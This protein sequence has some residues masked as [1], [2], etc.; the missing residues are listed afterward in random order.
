MAVA[1]GLLLSG[2]AS[3]RGGQD[4]ACADFDK[5]AASP[6]RSGFVSD[7]QRYAVDNRGVEPQLA[8]AETMALT[9]GPSGDAAGSEA[10]SVSDLITQDVFGTSVTQAETGARRSE[11]DIEA[12]IKAMGSA[13]EAKR[14][15]G[16]SIPGL[17]GAESG[18]SIVVEGE[19]PIRNVL[20]LSGGGQWGAYGAGL[21]LGLACKEPKEVWAQDRNVMPCMT[22]SVDADTGKEQR[23]I[24][25]SLI[26]FD[27]I[28]DMNIGLITGVSTGGLQSLLLMAVLDKTQTKDARIQ[29][30]QQ[31]LDS[32]SPESESV[33]VKNGG[34]RAVLF[35]G[36]VAGTDPL[37]D[38]VRGVL[39]KEF[40]FRDRKAPPEF[41]FEEP[42]SR[43][44]VQQIAK[45]PI[46]TIVGVV[47]GADGKFK[48]VNMRRMVAQIAQED[49]APDKRASDCVLATT[50]ASSAMPVFHQQLCVL[51]NGG[52][53]RSVF[54]AEIG[55]AFRSR[56]NALTA[57]PR[58]MCSGSLIRSA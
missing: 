17:V 57:T 36:S 45:S 22:V 51:K 56:Y 20:L 53:R 12:R 32:Y 52:V 37:L 14:A 30:L 35:R 7:I 6:K 46:T 48:Y 21:F 15:G 40:P 2:C 28:D 43:T 27:R 1:S 9:R 18:N 34:F 54:I 42:V 29:A 13:A 5:Y 24:K 4:I 31:L 44:L 16:A 49:D 19:L 10:L 26:S 3:T 55:E 23:T 11:R 33:L 41:G 50:L 58:D 25:S 39:N 38:H 47:E 8:G